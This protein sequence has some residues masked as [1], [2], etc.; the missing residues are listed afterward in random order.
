L[1]TPFWWQKINREVRFYFSRKYSVSGIGT[2]YT[3]YM[4]PTSPL[5]RIQLSLTRASLPSK[6]VYLLSMHIAR[7]IMLSVRLWRSINTHTAH[8]FVRQVH[9]FIV[10]WEYYF[11]V[12]TNNI[13]FYVPIHMC[14]II[15]LLLCR[16]IIDSR[17]FHI[18]I[19]IIIIVIIITLL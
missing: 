1:R 3:Y 2:Y 4:T 7:D 19:I 18:I 10:I 15:L 6:I 8:V 17:M 11:N 13:I 12:P 16:I 14:A 5:I 9:T